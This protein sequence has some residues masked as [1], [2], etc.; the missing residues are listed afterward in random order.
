MKKN[1]VLQQFKNIETEVTEKTAFTAG[2]GYKIH[3]DTELQQ[4]QNEQTPEKI[5][6]NKPGKTTESVKENSR[7][8]YRRRNGNATDIVT[9]EGIRQE[10]NCAIVT[11]GTQEAMPEA[12]TLAG[13]S[14]LFK[15]FGDVTRLKILYSLMHSELRVQ[16]IAN[17]VEMSSS[18]VSHQLRILRQSSL[19]SSKRAG[20]TVI[21]R[22]AD[23]HVRTMLSQA[24]EHVLE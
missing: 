10:H 1:T 3:S 18:A 2:K 24:M 16:Q 20:K 23:D 4:L 14:E 6:G 8:V 12:E 9:D 21:Y 11:C 7:S 5:T 13:V 22:L 15:V 19:V 17:E